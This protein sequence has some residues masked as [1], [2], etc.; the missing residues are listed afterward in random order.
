MEI[1]G[2]SISGNC[3]KVKWTAD[4]IGL[5]YRWIETH[6]PRDVVIC[7]QDRRWGHQGSWASFLTWRVTGR[8]PVPISEPQSDGPSMERAI[9][10]FC[11]NGEVGEIISHRKIWDVVSSEDIYPRTMILASIGSKQIIER[12]S[13]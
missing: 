12:R 4:W 9:E 13:P 10:N 5:S 1:F 6:A 2:D 11:L 8:T 3:L 7:D